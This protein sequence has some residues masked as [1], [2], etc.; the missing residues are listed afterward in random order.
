MTVMTK[1]LVRVNPNLWEVRIVST[2]PYHTETISNG[3]LF[4]TDDI[5]NDRDLVIAV[6]GAPISN[7]M[8]P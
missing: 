3:V 8:T 2:K 1:K 7:P 6:L 4:S 5:T